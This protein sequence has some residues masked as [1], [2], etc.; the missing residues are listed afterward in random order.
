[1]RRHLPPEPVSRAAIWSRRLG[2]LA[3]AAAALI[4]VL[5]RLHKLDAGAAL[6]C[7]GVVIAI[8][9]GAV[10][11]FSV[12]CV[13]IWRWGG[14]G[15]GAAIYGFLFAALTLAWPSYLA[16]A[17]LRL[18]VLSDI[19]TDVDDP[20]DFSHSHQAL[21]ARRDYSPPN[22]TAAERSEQAAAYPD[23]KPIVIDVDLD[24]AV[25]LALKAAAARGWRVVE[26]RPA[27]ARS[28]DAHIDFLDR[29]LILGT[30]EDVAVRLRPLAGQ[31]RIDVRAASRHGRHDFGFNARRIKQFAEELQTQE[32]QH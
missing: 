9:L 11:S 17:A 6:A 2:L 5:A 1:M 24:E 27:S 15:L 4:V 23:V 7:F 26:Q 29:T 12:A 30:D 20:P 10:F 8:A 14:R 22:P 16:V 3:A 21:K 25:A 18:P 28:G 32:E 19:S 31:T 13:S